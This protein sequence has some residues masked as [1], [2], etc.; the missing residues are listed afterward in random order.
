M[1]I[2][3]LAGLPRHRFQ[4]TRV[5]VAKTRH[6]S[7][8]RT[9]E[10]FAA[11]RIDKPDAMTTDRERRRFAQAAMHDAGFLAHD[12][13]FSSGPYCDSAA[14]LASVS[15]RRVCAASPPSAKVAA[16]RACADVIAPVR[17]GKK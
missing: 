13:E 7:T 16:A 15:R 3:Q 8:A 2:G 11:I 12:V 17:L 4:Y 1:R 9:V 14:S 6:R 5:L 10:H